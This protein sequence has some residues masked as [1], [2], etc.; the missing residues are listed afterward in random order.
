MTS[1]SE[2]YNTV[3]DYLLPEHCGLCL[4][5]PARGFCA[6]CRDEFAIVENPCAGCGLTQPVRR[7]P[8]ETNRWL[9]ERVVVPLRYEFPLSTEIHAMK[10]SRRRLNG[11]ALGLLLAEHLPS[12]ANLREID[13]LVAVPLHRRRLR[14][15]GFSQSLEIARA[16]STELAI[17][18]LIA[19]IR[20]ARE[21]RPQSELDINE[22]QASVTGAFSVSRDLRG[23]RIAVVDDFITTGATVNALADALYSAGARN[24]QAWSV[25]RTL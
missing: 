7:C 16:I 5:Q 20:R 13:A 21:T 25:A 14:Q 3:L 24:V 1:V 18:L 12:R 9:L 6:S 17:P 19:G 2:V 10:Y 15:R 23:L 22:R 8:R 4:E 11:R